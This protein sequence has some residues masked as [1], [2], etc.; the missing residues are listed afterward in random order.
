MPFMRQTALSLA[1][2]SAS[3]CSVQRVGE[4]AARAEATADSAGRYAAI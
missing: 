2:L 1:V 4:A 3:A